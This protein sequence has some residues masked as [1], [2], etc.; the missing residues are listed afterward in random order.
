MPYALILWII[1]KNTLFNHQDKQGYA[2]C[3]LSSRKILPSQAEVDHKDP[4]TFEYLLQNFL[5]T[6]KLKFKDIS[7]T[8][9]DQKSPVDLSGENTK[10]QWI[11]FHNELCQLRI[12]ERETHKG[13]SKVHF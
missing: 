11:Q 5:R 6:Y 2:P 7:L 10:I 8:T 9:K 13:I 12:I 3:Q 4:H 1:K